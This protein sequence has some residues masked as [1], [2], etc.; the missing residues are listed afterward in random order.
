MPDM[1]NLPEQRIDEVEARTHK[2]RG[3]EAAYQLKR[4]CTGV[5]QV[6]GKAS[7]GEWFSHARSLGEDVLLRS[8]SA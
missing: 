7:G 8:A 4:S 1:A 3:V 6:A 2:L 5:R